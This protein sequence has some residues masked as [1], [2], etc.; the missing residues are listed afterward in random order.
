MKAN[1]MVISL[2]LFDDFF[3][4]RSKSYKTSWA[5]IQRKYARPI[6]TNPDALCR[7]S[8]FNKK[9]IM[10]ITFLK[11]AFCFIRLWLSNAY[12]ADSRPFWV[13]HSVFW[14]QL[15]FNSSKTVYIFL[16]RLD[17]VFGLGSD[18]KFYIRRFQ[19]FTKRKKFYLQ[20]HKNMF[21]MVLL[22]NWL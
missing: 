16:D 3:R 6:W 20:S 14:K 9:L 18:N 15:C 2:E 22:R 1:V 17:L 21:S 13:F 19:Y 5:R 11:T 12:S 7:W 10:S 4:G 8:R